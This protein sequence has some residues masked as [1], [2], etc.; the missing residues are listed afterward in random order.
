MAMDWLGLIDT[1]TLVILIITALGAVIGLGIYIWSITRYKHKFRI[2]L[3]TGT[4]TIIIDD[5]AKQ[6]T[7][8]DGITWWKLLKRKHI[9]AVPPAD[10]LDVTERGR[11]SVEAYYSDEGGY[12][13]EQSAIEKDLKLVK[14]S[15]IGFVVPFLNKQF[16]LF[17][18]DVWKSEKLLP[19]KYC[20]IKDK[21]PYTTGTNVL[22]TKQKV[23]MVNQIEKAKARKGFNWKE[24][25]PLIVGAT[26]LVLMIAVVFIFFDNIV[27]PITPLMEKL[28]NTAK[29]Q[30]ETA[31][32]MN[33]LI[34]QKQIIPAG[35]I[36]NNLPRQDNT[37]LPVPS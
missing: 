4:K 34:L 24:H 15:G 9:I 30:A 14:N 18:F 7:D 11:H 36:V 22:T 2:K 13:F 27:A 5:K 35:M 3:I 32:L 8:K 19:G 33:E 6:F 16:T 12:Q 31:R 26:A 29:A 1:T 10:T 23:I 20:F 17:N 37:T 25:I 21:T 28:D